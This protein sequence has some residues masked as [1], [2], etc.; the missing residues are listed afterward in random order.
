MTVRV[1]RE[2]EPQFELYGAF[3]G[4]VLGGPVNT[5]S[6]LTFTATDDYLIVVPKNQDQMSEPQ[7]ELGSTPSSH[8][9]TVGS[10]V[11]R[12]ADTMSIPAANLPWPTEE[13]LA[14]SIKM[15]G[16]MTYADTENYNEVVFTR[17][18]VDT[19]NSIRQILSTAGGATGAPT[20]RQASSG[21]V[22]SVGSPTY[23]TPDINVPFNIASRHGS[24]F[25]NGAVDGTALTANNTPTAL[26]YLENTD[27]QLGYDFM[28]TIEMFLMWKSDLT[29]AGIAEASR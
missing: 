1:T 3:E 10:T 28:G 17:W 25:V 5:I 22:D 12:A 4:E 11:T 6:S 29:D 7:V 19:N 8:I 24:T 27:L 15:S 21:V 14:L 20:F 23:Y 2:A 9:P 16:T 13:P 26:P 18:E